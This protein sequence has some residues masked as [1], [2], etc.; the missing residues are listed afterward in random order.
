[1]PSSGF[2]IVPSSVN[3]DIWPQLLMEGF[4]G[5]R[6]LPRHIFRSD[7]DISLQWKRYGHPKEKQPI[8][9]GNINSMLAPLY[10]QTK[11]VDEQNIMHALLGLFTQTR[12]ALN[13]TWK[14]SIFFNL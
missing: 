14:R 4:L 13:I 5:V 9:L 7:E 2:E 6:L 12:S 8:R 11:T 10:V 3:I 1:M